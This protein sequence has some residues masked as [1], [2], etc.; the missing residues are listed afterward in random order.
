VTSAAVAK[1]AAEAVV[2]AG[3]AIRNRCAV[4]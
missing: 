3:V 2:V 1:A 4:M